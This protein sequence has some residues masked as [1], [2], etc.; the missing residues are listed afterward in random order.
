MKTCPGDNLYLNI[1]AN[2]VE[3]DWV[4]IG[5]SDDTKMGNDDVVAVYKNISTQSFYAASLIDPEG[6]DVTK[7]I[8]KPNSRV[9]WN[10]F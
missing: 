8:Q 3:D 1:T 4:A 7:G 2:I 9:K 5:F 10:N 6:M